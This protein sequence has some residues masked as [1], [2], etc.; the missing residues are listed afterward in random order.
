MKFIKIN[1]NVEETR[2]NENFFLSD[3]IFN[4][5]KKSLFYCATRVNFILLLSLLEYSECAAE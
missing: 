3:S 1:C 5:E 2:D 4:C